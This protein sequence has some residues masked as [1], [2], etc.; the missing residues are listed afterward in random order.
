MSKKLNVLT[1]PF[2]EVNTEKSS[3]IADLREK[4]RKHQEAL[5]LHN[6]S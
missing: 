5:G 1:S 2:K 6:R 3:S 4:A